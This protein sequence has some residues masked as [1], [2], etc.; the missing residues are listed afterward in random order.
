MEGRVV[1]KLSKRQ[2]R[3]QIAAQVKCLIDDCSPVKGFSQPQEIP[4]SSPTPVKQFLESQYYVPDPPVPSEYQNISCSTSVASS[5]N[6]TSTGELQMISDES[7]SE[8]IFSDSDS[9]ASS[10]DLDSDPLTS[11]STSSLTPNLANPSATFLRGWAI[12]NNLTHTSITELL[13][14][15]SSNP[16]ICNLPKNARTLLKTPRQID[17]RVIGNGKFYYIGLQKEIKRIFSKYES[18][19]SIN[20]FLYYLHFNIDGLP[21]HKSTKNCFWPI[22][23]RISNYPREHPFAVAIYYGTG[24]PP[25]NDF[26]S[27][28]VNE[29]LELYQN[30]LQVNGKTIKVKCMSFCCDTPARSYVKATMA[31]NSYQGCDKCTVKGLYVNKRMVFLNSNAPPRTD[32]EFVHQAYGNYHKGV[33]VYVILVLVWYLAFL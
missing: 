14:W 26:F 1:K 9:N 11:A 22:L 17:V 23:C 15:F 21:L 32:E 25:L 27:E 18:D 16:N 12:K 29:V 2:Q 8:Y 6:V 3:R 5:S 19:S 24:K 20:E 28:F 30:H 13:T 7:D 31:H 10:D 4:D 33:R